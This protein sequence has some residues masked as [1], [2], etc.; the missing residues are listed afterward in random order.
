MP[1]EGLHIDHVILG[2][3]DIDATISRLRRDHGLGAVPGGVHRGGTTN[4]LI[5]LAPPTFLELL[6][7][8]DTALPDGAWLAR[9]LDGAD[10]MIWW[11]LGTAD[12]HESARRRGLPVQTAEMTWPDGSTSVFH[13]AGMPR[14]PL[15]FF[16]AFGNSLV[17]RLRIW[18]HRYR[19]AAH[20]CDPGA[21]LSV[22][23]GDPPQCID[24]WLGDHGL[25]VRYAT[26]APPGISS[27]T[28]ATARGPVEIR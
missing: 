15:P 23:I 17:D 2:V 6:G 28:I 14:Y 18:R 9:T 7:V 5:P 21:I 25:P 26:G 4:A 11:A 22:E 10:R 16:I 8:G 24:A 12:L 3:V 13:S 1:P 20:T 27:V 19:E